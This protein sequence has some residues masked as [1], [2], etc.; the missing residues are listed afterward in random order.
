MA[1]MKIYDEQ[2]FSNFTAHLEFI[3]ENAISKASLASVGS[4][5]VKGESLQM[6]EKAMSEAVCTQD[7]ITNNEIDRFF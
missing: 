3:I 4:K 7:P 6:I 2:L 1:R 5:D